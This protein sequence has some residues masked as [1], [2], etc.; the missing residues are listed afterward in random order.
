MPCRRCLQTARCADRSGGT[1]C[2]C[3]YLP[4]APGGSSPLR[5]CC[6]ARC[7]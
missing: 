4:S 1:S 6:W 5:G 2:A 7:A 3:R